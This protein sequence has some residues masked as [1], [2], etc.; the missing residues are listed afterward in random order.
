MFNLITN[1]QTEG[2]TL[3]LQRCFFAAKKNVL[4]DFP[5]TDRQSVSELMLS[6]RE[7]VSRVLFL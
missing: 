3:G 1:R 6:W 5:Y 2:Q 4:K 7:K